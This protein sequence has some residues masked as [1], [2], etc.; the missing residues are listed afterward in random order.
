MKRNASF[1]AAALAFA[2][3]LW[4]AI[5]VSCLLPYLGAK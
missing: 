5:E 1:A 3:A 4:A 2:F